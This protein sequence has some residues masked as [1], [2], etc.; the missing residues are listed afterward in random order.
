[1]KSEKKHKL[2]IEQLDK[3]IQVLKH[4]GDIAK[5]PSGWIYAIRTALKMSLRQ[6]GN[7]LSITPQSMREIEQREKDGS[8]TLKNL[9]E[10]GKALNMQLV[11]GFIPEEGSL[12]QMIEKKAR[13][14]AKE[15]VMRTSQS[16]MLEDQENSKQRIEK[17]IKERAEEI[18]NEMPGYLWD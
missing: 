2:L 13:I 8:I 3:K 14:I 7:R 11:Y 16:M 10:A 9:R 15:I 1:M 6:M 12:E 5:P 18:K 4:V 17:A